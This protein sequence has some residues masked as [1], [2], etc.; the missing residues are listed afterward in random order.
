[1][2]GRFGESGSLVRDCIL[3]I[4]CWPAAVDACEASELVLG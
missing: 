4:S 2:L 3:R 1:M